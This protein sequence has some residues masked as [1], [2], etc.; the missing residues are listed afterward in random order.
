MKLEK[1]WLPKQIARASKEVDLWP[2]HQQEYMCLGDRKFTPTEL[3]ERTTIRIARLKEELIAE[4]LSL[5]NLIKNLEL[6]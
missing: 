4:E 2:I 3:V 6:P 5:V 1:G